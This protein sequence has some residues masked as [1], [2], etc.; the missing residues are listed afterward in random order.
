MTQMIDA[1]R[2]SRGAFSMLAIDQRG[3]LRAMLSE[4]AGLGTV[5]DDALVAFKVA[6]TK[7]VSPSASAML[8]D[9]QYGAQAVSVAACPVILAADILT[10]SVPGGAVDQ[11]AL[12]DELTAEAIAEFGASALKMLVPWT[13]TSRDAAID[14]S[15]RFM[16]LCNE[17]GLPG[18]V[19]GVVRPLDIASW[20]DADR[21]DALVEAARDLATT[22]PHLYK[23]EVPSYGLGDPASIAAVSRRISDVLDCPWVVLSSGVSAD[24]FPEAVAACRAG[25]AEGFLA[26]RAIWMDAITS[27]SPEEFLRTISVQRLQALAAGS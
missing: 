8:I 25:G 19:E 15:A 18:V 14:L 10:S 6:V 24:R 5:D 7:W 21:D 9:R 3:S 4:A 13:P 23:A 26:G 2:D 11:A 22:K 1:L 16:D 20:S 17:V 12:D 27:A